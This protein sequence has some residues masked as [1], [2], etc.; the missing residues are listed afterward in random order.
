[1]SIS[2]L[3]ICVAQN[4]NLF[5][6]YTFL[7]TYFSP[8]SVFTSTS[9]VPVVFVSSIFA[10]DTKIEREFKNVIRLITWINNRI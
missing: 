7:Y 4:L 3:G 6:S 1:M 5:C 9:D 2:D 8:V 10:E